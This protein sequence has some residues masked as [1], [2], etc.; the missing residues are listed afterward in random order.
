MKRFLGTRLVAVVAALWLPAL[1]T[2]E[3]ETPDQQKERIVVD[4]PCDKVRVSLGEGKEAV[5]TGDDFQMSGEA[6]C[7][8][9]PVFTLKV[10]VSPDA[11]LS[12][13]KVQLVDVQQ[14]EIPGVYDAQPMPRLVC[15]TN[16]VREAGLTQDGR[17]AKAYETDAFLPGDALG[18]VRTDQMAEWKYVEVEILPLAYNPAARKF[19]RLKAGRLEIVYQTD[20]GKKVF[21]SKGKRS[22]ARFREQIRASVV[23]FEQQAGKY[24]AKINR[25]KAEKEKQG[26]GM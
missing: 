16:G 22:A 8:G 26:K 10:L 17:R 24:D 9:V 25:Q 18:A 21:R 4:V 11:D 5:F 7:P 19:R 15:G 12:T 23:N 3:Q 14:A 1:A 6:G 13:V 2:A 20:S